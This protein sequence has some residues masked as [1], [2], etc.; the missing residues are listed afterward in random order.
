MPPHAHICLSDENW[1]I[2]YDYVNHDIISSVP[3]FLNLV[4]NFFNPERIPRNIIEAKMYER[5]D[6]KSSDPI[7]FQ[8][9]TIVY[10]W[11][12]CTGCKLSSL[13]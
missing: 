9:G 10:F 13:N 11:I 4:Y 12:Y 8:S 5:L 3:S 2:Y 6:Q 1:N 7:Y